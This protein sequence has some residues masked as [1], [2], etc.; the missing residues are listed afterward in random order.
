MRVSGWTTVIG[1]SRAIKRKAPQAETSARSA[2]YQISGVSVARCASIGAAASG[3]EFLCPS[4]NPA[5]LSLPE[6]RP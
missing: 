3:Q 4:T 5:L 6:V 1:K 2:H